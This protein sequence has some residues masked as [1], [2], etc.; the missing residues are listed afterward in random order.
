VSSSAD[1]NA[2]ADD[3]PKRLGTKRLGMMQYSQVTCDGP[4]GSQQLT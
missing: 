4:K 2:E 1:H 3:A